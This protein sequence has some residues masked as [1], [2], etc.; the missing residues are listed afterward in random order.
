MSENQEKSIYSADFSTIWR[1]LSS[2]QRRYVVARLEY[3]TK[4]EAAEAI[5]IQPNTAYSWGDEVE[6]AVQLIVND[7]AEN[8][9]TMFANALHK[10]VMVKIGGLDSDD[11]RI[12]QGVAS[13]IVERI[14]GSATQRRELSGKIETVDNG[15]K[16]RLLADIQSRMAQDDTRATSRIHSE[17]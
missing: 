17:P 2:N 8:A 11:E 13:E 9:M 7:A 14:L 3:P 1:A 16:Q 6:A 4:K 10:A 5:G 15:I 12:R